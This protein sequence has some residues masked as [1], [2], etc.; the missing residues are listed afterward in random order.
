M[1]MT[2]CLTLSACQRTENLTQP[3]LD[4]RAAVLERGC[5]FT[6]EITADF[7]DTTCEFSAECRYSPDGTTEV[8][9]LAPETISGISATVADDG[10]TLEF[11]GLLLDL[12]TLA[13]GHVAP[14]TAPAI[15][16]QC[17]AGEYISTVGAE[18][19][20]CL[21]T[22]LR[23]YD[24]DELTVLT[25]LSGESGVPISGEVAYQGSTVLF[26]TITDFSDSTEES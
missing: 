16:A 12:G 18:G 5:S 3:A 14:L 26:V 15:L 20:D 19:D 4:L 11:D 17:W 1:M 22:Y 10:A 2:L 9:I 7:G 24:N 21:V 13:G 25:R 6:A 8:T 23:G